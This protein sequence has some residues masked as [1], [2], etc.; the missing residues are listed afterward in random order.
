MTQFVE[1]EQER[2]VLTLTFT[3]VV[4]LVA[5]IIIT[6]ISIQKGIIT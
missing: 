1:N 6:L 2:I 4:E 5:L 3:I